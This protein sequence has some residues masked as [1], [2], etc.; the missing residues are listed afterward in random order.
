MRNADS[1]N[2]LRLNIKLKSKRGEPQAT[3]FGGL[4]LNPLTQPAELDE[5]D[6]Q[7]KTKA[8]DER[9]Q[10][11][12]AQMA[13][14]LEKKRLAQAGREDGLTAGA[15]RPAGGRAPAAPAR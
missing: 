3:D 5:D 14:L 12:E 4:A 7:G 1:T 6:V 2:E 11:E 10:R 8:L 15:S 9:R 13:A